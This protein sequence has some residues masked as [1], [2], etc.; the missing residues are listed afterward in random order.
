MDLFELPAELPGTVKEL[1]ALI[2]RASIEIDVIADF[3]NAGRT[4]PA[5][6]LDHWEYLLD[7]RDMLREAAMTLSDQAPPATVLEAK[8]HSTAEVSERLIS[9]AHE[10]GHAA[11]AVVLGGE[12]DAA[13]VYRPEHGDPIV[14]RDGRQLNGQCKVVPLT[15]VTE[16]RRHLVAAAGPVAEAI[17]RFGPS[18]TP[19][20]I[21]QVLAG[22][23]DFDELRRYALTAGAYA[24]DPIREVKPLVLRCWPAIAQ[25]A[26]QMDNGRPVT[27]ADVT[28]A[29]GLSQDRSMH[30]FECA[31]IRAGIRAVGGAA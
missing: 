11:V 8:P 24:S 9:A 4:L 27:H 20:Q 1:D 5:D 26:V 13:E 2:E 28:A 29:L 31:N 16:A 14:H 23:P 7:S 21:H 3:A 19:A 30:G 12:V 15:T 18:P 22:Q 25:L 17:A 6:V 10:A